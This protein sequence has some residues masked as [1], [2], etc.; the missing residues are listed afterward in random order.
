MLILKI[1]FALFWLLW[2]I[3]ALQKAK[4]NKL[5]ASA[6]Y[7]WFVIGMAMLIG[8]SVSFLK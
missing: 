2:C 3:V 7:F 4:E 6:F 8:I 1:I 5:Q